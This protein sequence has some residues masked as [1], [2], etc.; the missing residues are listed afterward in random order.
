M[1]RFVLAACFVGASA[2]D[3]NAWPTAT[4]DVTQPKNL[5]AWPVTPQSTP[6]GCWKTTILKDNATGWPGQCKGLTEVLPAANAPSMTKETCQQACIADPTCSVWQ[7]SWD[8]C[9][10]GQG[11]D[12]V[13]R[14]G[15]T[16]LDVSGAQRI[17]RGDVTVLK[18]MSN[19]YVFGLQDVGT[20]ASGTSAENMQRCRDWCYSNIYCQYWQFANG[21]CM[22]ESKSSPAQYPLTLVE[23][24]SA[25]TGA[26]STAYSSEGNPA[27]TIQGAEYIQHSCP[28]ATTP[29]PVEQSGSSNTA[30]WVGCGVAGL[31]GLAALAF[32]CMGSSGKG[33]TRAVKKTRAVKAAVPKTEAPAVVEPESVPLVPLMA[34]ASTP[35]MQYPAPVMQYAAAPMQYAAA[36]TYQPVQQFQTYIQ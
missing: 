2:I 9:F 21:K 7:W 32:C 33:G 10:T 27:R 25:S 35:F 13:D 28:P 17:Q 34:P 14:G 8:G 22:A 24:N 15:D 19:I 18:N 16:L 26:V 4:A 5:A 1:Q 29:A 36:P 11:N 31:L 20:Y 23:S 6:A 30:L 3:Y 12:C